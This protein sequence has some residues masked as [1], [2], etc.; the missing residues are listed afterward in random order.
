MR[1]YGKRSTGTRR[2]AD[3]ILETRDGGP[4][5]RPP[6]HTTQDQVDAVEE[7]TPETDAVILVPERGFLEFRR[8]LRFDANLSRHCRGRPR[9]IRVRTASQGSPGD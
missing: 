6:V 4:G 3:S 1:W 2:T 7:L 8:G 5:E 9:A